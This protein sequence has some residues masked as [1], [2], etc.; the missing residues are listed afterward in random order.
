MPADEQAMAATPEKATARSVGAK[1]P[2]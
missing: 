2:E 1:A